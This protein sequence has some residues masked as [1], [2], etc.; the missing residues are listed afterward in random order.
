MLYVKNLSGLH[1]GARLLAGAVMGS[2]AFHYGTTAVGIIFGVASAVTV[3]TSVLGY[4]PMCT[5]DAARR[6]AEKPSARQ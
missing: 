2:C 4:C 5:V 3:V 6:G 1:R